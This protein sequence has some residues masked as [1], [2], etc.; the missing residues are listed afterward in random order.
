[1]ALISILYILDKVNNFIAPYR[2]GSEAD[3]DSVCDGSIPSG[4]VKINSDVILNN[5][6]IKWVK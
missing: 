5:K 6:A 4:V 2:N 1:M 3:F